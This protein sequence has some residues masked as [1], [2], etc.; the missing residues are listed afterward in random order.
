MPIFLDPI[1]HRQFEFLLGLVVEEYAVECWGFVAMSNHYHAIMRPTRSNLSHA[2]QKLNGEYA[3][4]WNKRHGRVGHVFQGRFKDQIVA[5]GEYL[6]TLIRY[7]AR[8]PLRA[9]LVDDLS[10]WRAGSYR[11][12]AGLDLAPPFL[13]TETVWTQFG[14]A[15]IATLQ[16]RF[17][18][19]VLGDRDDEAVADRIR[20]NDRIIGDA[21]F[22]EMILRSNALTSSQRH[23]QPSESERGNSEESPIIT[24]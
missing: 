5:T 4:W 14:V 23:I 22:K 13:S 6:M 9:R 11:A 1:D 2:M 10:T 16:S 24:V 12:L 8:N 7:V 18:G 21:K 17:R 19:F 15:D 3:Q 20:S